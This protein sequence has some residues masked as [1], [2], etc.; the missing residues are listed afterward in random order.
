MAHIFPPYGIHCHKEGIYEPLD[1]LLPLF[2]LISCCRAQQC[3][4]HCWARQQ[5]IKCS[6][7]CVCGHSR[8]DP[9]TQNTSYQALTS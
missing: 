4:V 1:F 7:S 6:Q 8:D 5:E 9:E 2:L 3:I